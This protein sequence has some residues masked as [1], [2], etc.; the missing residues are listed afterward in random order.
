MPV[1]PAQHAD[2][3]VSST[4][5][6]L[7][8]G[9]R[10]GAPGLGPHAR[11]KAQAQAGGGSELARNCPL[12]LPGARARPASSRVTCCHTEDQTELLGN[13]GGAPA[14]A[15][16]TLSHRLWRPAHSGRLRKGLCQAL[17]SPQAP[18]PVA[19]HAGERSCSRFWSLMCKQKL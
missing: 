7:T 15:I 10:V 3:A 17:G 4:A 12:P 11:H 18:A 9:W 19:H 8:E 14:T 13:E 1:R 16:P 6:F 2:F 5:V